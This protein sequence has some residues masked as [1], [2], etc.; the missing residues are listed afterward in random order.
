MQVM[1]LNVKLKRWNNR[2]L[3]LELVQEVSNYVLHVVY[4]SSTYRICKLKLISVLSNA[5]FINTSAKLYIL[6]I[7]GFVLDSKCAEP[8]LK[9]LSNEIPGKLQHHKFAENFFSKGNLYM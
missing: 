1:V 4:M 3:Y 9:V 5:E 2:I 6:Y 7:D 8:I